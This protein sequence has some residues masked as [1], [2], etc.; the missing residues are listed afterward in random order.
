[1]RFARGLLKFVLHTLELLGWAGMLLALAAAFLSPLEYA[2]LPF[3][4]LAF[5]ISLLVCFLSLVF[6][7]MKRLRSA[8]IPLL[9]MVVCWPLIHR[10]VQ[11]P[12][13][14]P[15][16]KEGADKEIRVMSY[17]VRLF[18]L[19]NWSEGSQTR[20]SI[21]DQLRSREADI[22]CF[23]E[24]YHTNRKG[25][26][27]TRDTLIQVLPTPYFQ[28]RYTHKMN[29]EQYFGVVTFSRYPIIQKGDIPFESDD[30]NFCIWSDIQV[31]TDTFRVFNAHLASIRFQ[32]EDYSELKSELSSSG[33]L[34]MAGRL[35]MAFEKRAKQAEKVALEIAK[36]P[37]PVILCGDFNDPPVSYAYTT[38]SE[39]LTDGFIAAGR[40]TGSTYVGDFPSFRIDY[41][42][43]DP[44]F[45][46]GSFEILPQQFSD[47][48]AIE[49]S[50]WY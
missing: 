27:E 34:R 8:F 36:S 47:H 20:D 14:E 24:F 25:I 32:Q 12:F 41:I 45:K 7:L 38:L 37:H 9:I 50:L 39:G 42:L 16:S 11:S 22:L 4:G 33:V 49:A 43:H 5:P 28:E 46:T 29:G 2:W 19:Y 13:N 23:Q 26:F 35:Q 1:M 44:Q 18:D 48:H 10:F 3:F 17:N 31:D 30:N 6:R 15:P 21:I 40:G